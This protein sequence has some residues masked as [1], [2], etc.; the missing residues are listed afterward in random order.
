M[1]F[2]KIYY[3]KVYPIAPYV[4]E[5][6]GLE[7]EL[8][9]TDNVHEVLDLAQDTL[10]LWHMKK[11]PDLY[12]QTKSVAPLAEIPKR[13]EDKNR[14]APDTAEGLIYD[15][16]RAGD[17]KVLESFKFIID[18]R[19]STNEKVKEAYDRQLE[20][21]LNGYVGEKPT[22]TEYNTNV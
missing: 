16:S 20:F 9:E 13:Q 21:L 22:P 2:T 1:K 17:N 18:R 5:K 19:Y 10:D 7:I 14:P 12:T 8:Q 11:H 3:E 15:I 6:L 4:N